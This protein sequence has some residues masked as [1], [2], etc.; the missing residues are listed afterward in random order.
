MF[1][2]LLQLTC[3]E[4]MQA[5]CAVRCCCATTEYV[6]RDAMHLRTPAGGALPMLSG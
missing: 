5:V 3:R 4:H 2:Q 6:L 1:M